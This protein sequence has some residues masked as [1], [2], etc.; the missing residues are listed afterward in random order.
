MQLAI[1][2]ISFQASWIFAYSCAATVTCESCMGTR[3]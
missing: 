3:Y 2:G 1:C